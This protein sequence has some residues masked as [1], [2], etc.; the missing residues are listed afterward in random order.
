MG[1]DTKPDVDACG[2]VDA[3]RNMACPNIP[4]IVYQFGDSEAVLLEKRLAHGIV[5]F[6]AVSQ[7]RDSMLHEV[8]V[9]AMRDEGRIDL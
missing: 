8:C 9:A 2:E 3:C 7:K 1:C 6:E 4:L 5:D